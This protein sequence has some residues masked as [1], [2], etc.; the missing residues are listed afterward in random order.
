MACLTLGAMQLTVALALRARPRTWENPFLC[1]LSAQPGCCRWPRYICP[2][3][4]EL[5]G[6]QTLPLIDLA[7]V[8]GVSLLGYADIRLDRKLHP[9]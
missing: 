7:V 3:L 6:T 8:I 5:L 4:A 2:P 9:R 1:L